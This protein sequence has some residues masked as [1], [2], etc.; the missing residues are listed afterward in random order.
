[1]RTPC[2]VE[3]IEISMDYFRTAASSGLNL[4]RIRQ[5]LPAFTGG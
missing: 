5:I 2:H 4:P 3:A 1:M